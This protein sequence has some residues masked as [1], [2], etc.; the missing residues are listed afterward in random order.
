MYKSRV[1]RRQFTEKYTMYI[2]VRYRFHCMRVMLELNIF[3][4]E[5]L[6]SSI[7]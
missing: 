3:S 6:D 1:Y 5:A 7:F 2:Y 4:I